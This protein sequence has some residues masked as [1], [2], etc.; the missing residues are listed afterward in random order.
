MADTSTTGTVPGLVSN[1]RKEPNVTI[2]ERNAEKLKAAKKDREVARTNRDIAVI[3]Y[4]K[5]YEDNTR[6]E[7]EVESMIEE[8]EG[9]SPQQINDLAQSNNELAD[10]KSGLGELTEEYHLKKDAY[11]N[12]RTEL[13]GEAGNNEA[14]MD[15][16]QD[17]REGIKFLKKQINMEESRYKK[18]KSRHATASAKSGTTEDPELQLKV[19]KLAEKIDAADAELKHHRDLLKEAEENDGLFVS[20]DTP[21]G[22]QADPQT[23]PQTGPP[24]GPPA[25]PQADPPADPQTGPQDKYRTPEIP[26]EDPADL[27]SAEMERN[28][29][30]NKED[31]YYEVVGWKNGFR[32][33][34]TLVRR[35]PP[36]ARSYR[37]ENVNTMDGYL[38]EAITPR[39]TLSTLRYGAM[40]DE[41]EEKYLYG[42]ADQPTIQGVCWYDEYP[43]DM[44]KP[45]E[46]AGRPIAVDIFI[47]WKTAEGLKWSWETRS[48][49]GR[50]WGKTKA[51]ETIYKAALYQEKRY[52]EWLDNERKSEDREP[53]PRDETPDTEIKEEPVADGPATATN[54]PATQ[55]PTKTPLNDYRNMWCE[56]NDINLAEMTAEQRNQLIREYAAL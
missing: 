6:L 23:G 17:T 2:A 36:N 49:W 29:R 21:G 46:E 7:N 37:L 41:N 50:I 51:A 31:K 24:A 16:K 3:A 22:P 27:W 11:S 53:T 47:K 12:L 43:V 54:P 55:N 18:L 42:K 34:T 20:Q 35:G 40:K 26:T 33:K 48:S 30:G 38:D 15:E 10:V 28:E 8:T 32:G 1:K 9:A 39:I 45:G 5:A 4:A 13:Q 44:L 56:I 14:K 52:N 19:R 25:G